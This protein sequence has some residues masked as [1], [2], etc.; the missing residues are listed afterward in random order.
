LKFKKHLRFVLLLASLVVAM[1]IWQT[2]NLQTGRISDQIS[3]LESVLISP[4][5]HEQ[6]QTFG[7][8]ITAIRKDHP[9]GQPIG[10]HVWASWCSICKLEEH[11]IS[12][13][14]RD[15]PIMTIA[16]QSGSADQVKTH[17]QDRSLAW[18][19]WVD[20]RS[21]ISQQ[22]GISA[23]PTFMVIDA[24]GQLRM[25]AVGYTTELG[26]RARL[27]LSRWL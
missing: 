7:Q 5:G 26:M 1:Q 23:V 8:A 18:H 22:M 15:H 6:T 14:S 25:P 13:V 3:Q 4:D 17:L 21:E 9:A 20:S 10:L 11:S 2:W 27:W 24:Y 19:A 12:R 16:M